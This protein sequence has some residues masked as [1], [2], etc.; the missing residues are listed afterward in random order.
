MDFGQLV[1]NLA[2]AAGIP[3]SDPS[4]IS[5]LSNAELATAKVDDGFASKLQSGLLS[6][7][8]AK[9]HP[10]L[11]SH[12][13]ALA[14]N[15]LDSQIN[16]LQDEFQIPEDIKAEL[17]L[18]KSSYKRA[19]QLVRK[20]KELEA[21]KVGADAGDKN[22]LAQ[23][24]DALNSELATIKGQYSNEK[25]ALIESHKKDR[26]DWELNALYNSYDYATQMSKEANTKLAQA[27]VNDE[28]SKRG[29]RIENVEN[30]LRLATKEGTDFYE[31]NQKISI[32]DFID[33]TLATHKVLIIGDDKD[34]KPKPPT[35]TPPGQ[36]TPV[37]NKALAEFDKRVAENSAEN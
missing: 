29:L 35:Y 15:A 22:K 7:E 17:K 31:N 18:E 16:E 34:A 27:L 19:G 11:K 23:Q 28:M 2:S 21:K 37:V 3:A 12:Y 1:N 36:N 25:N 32:K 4:L 26:I 14:L 6:I 8:A 9:N 33:K 13:T 24:I 20:V 30:N 5:F 10:E